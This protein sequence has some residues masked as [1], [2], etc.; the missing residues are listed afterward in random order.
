MKLD[1]EYIIATYTFPLASSSVISAKA[2]AHAITI[3][4]PATAATAIKVAATGT[5]GRPAARDVWAVLVADAGPRV[6]LAAS[7]NR[8]CVGRP[9]E[10]LWLNGCSPDSSAPRKF[11]VSLKTSK[12]SKPSEGVTSVRFSYTVESV[13]ESDSNDGAAGSQFEVTLWTWLMSRSSLGMSK[14]TSRETEAPMIEGSPRATTKVTDGRKPI[15]MA[16]SRSLRVELS[17]M[18]T[19]LVSL[20][21][22]VGSY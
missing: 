18:G 21:F 9:K 16:T 2:R 22:L 19:R 17:G 11:A 8:H 15:S 12:K 5:T 3:M 6:F 4:N 14:P 7:K 1:H 20:L 13:F 10:K